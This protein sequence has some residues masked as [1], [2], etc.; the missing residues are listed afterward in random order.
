MRNL[1]NFAKSRSNYAA[2]AHGA[3]RARGGVDSPSGG[4]VRERSC[5]DRA[6]SDKSRHD[7]Q[8]REG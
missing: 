2:L 4:A 7:L 6:L 8:N 5:T 1:D 3:L